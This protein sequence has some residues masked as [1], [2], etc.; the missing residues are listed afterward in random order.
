MYLKVC[1]FGFSVEMVRHAELVK[2][3]TS[4]RESLETKKIDEVRR[5]NNRRGNWNKRQPYLVQQ[6]QRQ[7][8]HEKES[9]CPARC[10]RCRICSKVGHFAAVCRTKPTQKKAVGEVSYKSCPDP[11]QESDETFFLGS[12][13]LNNRDKDPWQVGN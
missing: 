6:R 5:R 9:I 3:Q 10:K 8:Q 11:V 12:V 1:G 13:N 4:E 7:R 2:N